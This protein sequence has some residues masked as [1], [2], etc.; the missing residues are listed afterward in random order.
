[1]VALE[2][3]VGINRMGSFY[4]I[5]CNMRN[6]VMNICGIQNIKVFQNKT[7]ARFRRGGDLTNLTYILTHMDSYA[8]FELE[9]FGTINVGGYIGSIILYSY[10]AGHYD[11]FVQDDLMKYPVMALYV[12]HQ[13]QPTFASEP[14]SE[15]ISKPVSEPVS[16]SKAK[17]QTKAQTKPQT[18]AQT[19]AQTKPQTKAQTKP[20]TKADL[21]PK[22]VKKS[23]IDKTSSLISMSDYVDSSIPDELLFELLKEI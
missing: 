9:S 6:L 20:Q 22:I 17:P 5:D 7:D 18:K 1:M 19:K 21:F 14:V 2:A 8:G 15:A 3:G 11:A 10:N 23:K 13:I 12:K 4:A 16:K